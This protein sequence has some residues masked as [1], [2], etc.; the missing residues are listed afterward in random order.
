[1]ITEKVA[2]FAPMPKAIVRIAI[3]V[4][5]GEVNHVRIA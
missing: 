1:L 2:V 5:P 4:K 3:A